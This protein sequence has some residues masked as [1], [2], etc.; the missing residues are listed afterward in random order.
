MNKAQFVYVTYVAT[1][2]QKLWNALTDAEMTK[3][4]WV[5]HRNA[6]D[7]KVGSAWEHQDYDDPSVIDI[8]GKVIEYD[9]PRRLVLS[10]AFPENA[11]PYWPHRRGTPSS[12]P[13]AAADHTL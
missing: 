11:W 9:P 12:A 5:R 2:P 6:S 3:Q 8:V 13:I 1:T 10:W 4:Y 7:W